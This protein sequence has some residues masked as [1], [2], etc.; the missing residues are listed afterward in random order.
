[1]THKH[2]SFTIIALALGLTVITIVTVVRGVLEPGPQIAES[3][4]PLSTSHPVTERTSGWK[5]YRNEKYGYEA[6]YPAEGE[7]FVAADSAGVNAPYYG[8]R[9]IFSSRIV[10]EP[11]D[12]DYDEIVVTVH[13][14]TRGDRTLEELVEVRQGTGNVIDIYEPHTEIKVDG[15]RAWKSINDLNGREIGASVLVLADR[16][17]YVIAIGHQ[18]TSYD[19][20]AEKFYSDFLQYFRLL[21]I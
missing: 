13:E 12:G 8:S 5:T 3:P 18:F 6:Q 15:V 10:R 17:Y 4:A 1:M 9:V 21:E 7:F 20:E 11:H 2:L 16:Y 14:N 19:S